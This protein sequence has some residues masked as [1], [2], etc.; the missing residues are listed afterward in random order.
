MKIQPLLSSK[1]DDLFDLSLSTDEVIFE[2]MEMTA[3][4]IRE[5]LKD[6]ED[7]LSLFEEDM[8]DV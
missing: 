4:E 8:G 3:E 1:G 2:I 5:L 7:Q 6:I